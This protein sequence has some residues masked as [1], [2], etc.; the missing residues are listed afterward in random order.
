MY[1]TIAYKAEKLGF[2]VRLGHRV[3]EKQHNKGNACSC[4]GNGPCYSILWS[5]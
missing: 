1:E 4:N 5:R 2:E 3:T